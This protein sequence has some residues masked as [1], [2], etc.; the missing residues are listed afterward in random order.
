MAGISAIGL[1][2]LAGLPSGSHVGLIESSARPNPTIETVRALAAALGVSVGW[3]ANGE[4]EPPD[5]EAVRTAVEG[6]RAN[7]PAPDDTGTFR[8]CDC[9]KAKVG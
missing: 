2:K 9:E 5:P 6:V 8:V 3:L 1:S 7:Q 4:G